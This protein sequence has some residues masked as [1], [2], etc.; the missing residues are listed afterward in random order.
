MKSMDARVIRDPRDLIDFTE[1]EVL[2][3][4][5]VDPIITFVIPLAA[6]VV[7]ERGGMLIHGTIISREYGLPCVTVADWI[8]NDIHT[9]DRVTVDG[10]L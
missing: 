8:L 2:V 1:C 3:C 10:F 4:Q 9:G 6:T 5:G 7:E